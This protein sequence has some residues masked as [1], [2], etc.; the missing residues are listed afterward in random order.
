MAMKRQ[1]SSGTWEFVFKNTKLLPKAVSVTFD[2][3]EQGLEFEKRV[4]ALFAIGQVPPELLN[5]SNTHE[6]F[7]TLGLTIRTYLREAPEVSSSDQQRLSTIVNE[8]G[9]KPVITLSGKWAEDWVREL[10]MKKLK[11]T[12]IRHRVGALRRCLDWAARQNVTALAINPLNQLPKKFSIYS[13]KDVA[14]VGELI[15]DEM[16]DRRLSADGKEEESIRKVID[17]LEVNRDAAMLLFDLALESAMR[18]REMY[19][20]DVR[21]IKFDLE[22]I[23]LEK[24]KNGDKRQVPMTTV[25]KRLLKEYIEAKHTK[26]G[27]LFPW[28]SG[29]KTALELNDITQIVSKTFA[30][31][32]ERAGC[33]D[34]HFHDLRH[35]ATSRI[36]ERTT[37]TD[38][39]IASIT[40]HKSINVLKRYANLRGSQL[41][42]RLW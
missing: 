14:D 32:F 31:I 12:S 2:T 27:H 20:L 13:K 36:Y 4:D 40:G 1:R 6:K 25:S 18:M 41:S 38:V 17:A 7:K 35:E 19:T 29:Q 11:P 28:Y 34:L 21:Q 22:T 23:F 24:T 30:D 33:G 10:K 16:R 42:G 5:R 3:Y 37:L 39:Q 9:D 8:I 26:R 15:E